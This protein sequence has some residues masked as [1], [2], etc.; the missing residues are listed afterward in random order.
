[1]GSLMHVLA[2]LEYISYFRLQLMYDTSREIKYLLKKRG[3]KRRLIAREFDC[4]CFS[5]RS[6]NPY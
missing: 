5:V 3:L 4:S 1:M 6:F 2:G